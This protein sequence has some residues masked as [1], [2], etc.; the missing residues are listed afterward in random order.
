MSH[1]S[2]TNST[3]PSLRHTLKFERSEWPALFGVLGTVVMLHIVGWGL[4]IY[5]N[6]DPKY[7]ALTDS[8]GALI[9]ASAGALAYGFGLR[10]AFDADHNA[11]IDDDVVAFVLFTALC[12]GIPT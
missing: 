6:S 9:Y 4:F 1:T 2:V 7:H 12:R 11:A 3:R 8:K 5:Y 10:H